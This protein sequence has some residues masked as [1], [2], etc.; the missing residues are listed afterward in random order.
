ML[1][2]VRFIRIYSWAWF[3]FVYERCERLLFLGKLQR[4]KKTKQN[5]DYK[6]VFQLG[7]AILVLIA[8]ISIPN[9]YYQCREQEILIIWHLLVKTFHSIQERLDC[10]AQAKNIFKV[11]STVGFQTSLR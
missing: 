9:P 8:S 1:F 5:L 2:M 3:D 7:N 11:L 10:S 4:N 6:H